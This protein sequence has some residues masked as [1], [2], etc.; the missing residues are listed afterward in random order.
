MVDATAFEAEYTEYAAHGEKAAF[1]A[2]AADLNRAD[3]DIAYKGTSHAF[4]AGLQ[5]YEL[6][7]YG[8]AKR[9]SVEGAF[10]RSPYDTALSSWTATETG[11]L[12]IDV[13]AV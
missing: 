7:K 11:E 10:D 5:L 6:A 8:I 3:F 9:N 13:T 12:E 1:V 2:S 4:V